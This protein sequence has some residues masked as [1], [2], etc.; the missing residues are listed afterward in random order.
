M[1]CRLVSTGTLAQYKRL[2]VF[3]RTQCIA[4]KCHFS[5]SPFPSSSSSSSRSHVPII[6]LGVALGIGAYLILDRQHKKETPEAKIVALIRTLRTCKQHLDE[7]DN[8][9][10]QVEYNS[11]KNVKEELNRVLNTLNIDTENLKQHLT[12]F[13]YYLINSDNYKTANKDFHARLTPHINNK[14][15]ISHPEFTPYILFIL[16]Q[17]E[18]KKYEI[19]D[20]LLVNEKYQPR[21]EQLRTLLSNSL[22]NTLT[23]TSQSLISYQQLY[24]PLSSACCYLQFQLAK[25]HLLNQEY[26]RAQ[27]SALH[28]LDMLEQLKEKKKTYDEKNIGNNNHNNRNNNSNVIQAVDKRLDAGKPNWS[29][30]FNL[31]S[32]VYPIPSTPNSGEFSHIYLGDFSSDLCDLLSDC[33]IQQQEYSQALPWIQTSL[34]H[35]TNYMQYDWKEKQQRIKD[36]EEEAKRDEENNNV[37]NT[38]S[39]IINTHDINSS[40]ADT[41]V[42]VKIS[43]YL[44]GQPRI[45]HILTRM[46]LCQ[47]QLKQDD[48]AYETALTALKIW[49]QMCILYKQGGVNKVENNDNISNGDSSSSISPSPYTLHIPYLTSFTLQQFFYLLDHPKHIQYLA[50][51]LH[52]DNNV[53]TTSPAS[54]SLVTTVSSLPPALS[55]YLWPDY[56]D[57]NLSLQLLELLHILQHIIRKKGNIEEADQCLKFIE[58]IAYQT[59]NEDELKELSKHHEQLPCNQDTTN[60]NNKDHVSDSTD[61]Q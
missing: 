44:L 53:S 39:S 18:H 35:W 52:Q 11:L 5:T 30:D 46:C 26:K 15:H 31:D 24:G 1:H 29:R 37:N 54:S 14:L 40:E 19:I 42:P 47:H 8:I 6:V 7:I 27:Q 13:D 50:D 23:Y 12:K 25:A 33:Y 58:Q 61:S 36:V 43:P 16:S 3:T 49:K 28:C 17:L 55:D 22:F 59:H 32:D 41:P 21:I 45:F 48:A 9:L 56:H 10:L 60:H 57:I 34:I 4:Y 38:N 20:L 51:S 2:A